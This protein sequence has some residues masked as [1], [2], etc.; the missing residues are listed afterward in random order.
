MQEDN[1]PFCIEMGFEQ[2]S[3]PKAADTQEETT[4]SSTQQAATEEESEAK[5]LF[6][7]EKTYLIT[8]NILMN[9]NRVKNKIVLCSFNT[10]CRFITAINKYLKYFNR[11]FKRA[12]P[13]KTLVS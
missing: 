3:E 2:K 13:F 12:D 10:L 6:N 9:F 8:Q 7:S 4:G 11:A 1:C 5:R